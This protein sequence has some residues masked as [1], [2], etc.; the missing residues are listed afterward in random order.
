MTTKTTKT[1]TAGFR[2]FKDASGYRLHCWYNLGT[3]KVWDGTPSLYGTRK[4]AQA[5]AAR[6]CK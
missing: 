2:I 5:A 1:K 6:R 3:G 4:E